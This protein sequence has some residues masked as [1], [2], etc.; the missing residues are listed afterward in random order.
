VYG[1]ICFQDVLA[2]EMFQLISRETELAQL[3]AHYVNLQKSYH[4][5][6]LQFLEKMIPD[7]ETYISKCCN[8]IILGYIINNIIH[9]LNE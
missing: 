7:L 5:N 1:F 6:A 9:L 4:E 8:N 2:S 3:V